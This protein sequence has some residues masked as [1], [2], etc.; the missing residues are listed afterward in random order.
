MHFRR[1][2]TVSKLITRKNIQHMHK[3]KLYLLFFL[4]L[5]IKS[6]GQN[7]ID[8]A[9]TIIGS[10]FREKLTSLVR[11]DVPLFDIDYLNQEIKNTSYK[12][13][14]QKGFSGVYFIK[15]KV[16]P[17]LMLINNVFHECA[18]SEELFL[19]NRIKILKDN[20]YEIVD[21]DIDSLIGCVVSKYY[22]VLV[23]SMDNDFWE[24]KLPRKAIYFNDILHQFHDCYFLITKDHSYLL[25]TDNEIQPIEELNSVVFDPYS[26]FFEPKANEVIEDYYLYKNY[27]KKK[28]KLPKEIYKYLYVEDIGTDFLKSLKPQGAR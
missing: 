19:N 22:G 16:R 24:S 23:D 28:K 3:L 2:G 18:T 11:S 25:R 13:L 9:N 27:T 7:K 14:A 21:I 5:S 26:G 17:R 20:K 10:L 12:I 6:L 1:L 4:L 8:S 15:I